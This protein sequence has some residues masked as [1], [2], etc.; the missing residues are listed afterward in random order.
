MSA[1][2]VFTEDGVIKHNLLQQFDELV[3][4]VCGHEGLDCD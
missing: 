2:P 3:G 1:E 4:Q